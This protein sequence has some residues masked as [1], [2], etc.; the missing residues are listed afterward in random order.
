MQGHEKRVAL[1]SLDMR[2]FRGPIYRI[3]EQ[4]TQ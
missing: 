3:A 1:L 2:G 4:S